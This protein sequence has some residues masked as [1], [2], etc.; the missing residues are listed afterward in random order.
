MADETALR[1]QLVERF[2]RYLAVASQ[3]DA[4]ATTLPST[5]ASAPWP[6]CSPV[7]CAISD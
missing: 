6:S 5:P 1:A 2:F 3:S 4:G 7:S